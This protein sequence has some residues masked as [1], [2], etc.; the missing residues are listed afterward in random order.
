M[1]K[2]KFVQGTVAE[3]KHWTDRLYSLKIDAAIKPFQPG[4]FGRLGLDI[5]G[6]SIVRPYS[7]VNA[8]GEPFLEFYSITVPDGVLSNHLRHLEPGAPL[9]IA[10][11]AAGFFTLDEVP[12][13]RDLWM[14]ST[15]TALG[16]FLSILKTDL[17]W[18]RFEKIVLVHAVRHA[19][20][21]TYQDTIQKFA[22]RDPE[23]FIMIPFV[24]REPSEV[25]MPGRIPPAIQSGALEKRAGLSIHS[26]YSQVMIC[27]NPDM[28]K[29]TTD[30]LKERGLKKNRR[31]ERG[32][33]TTEN[34]W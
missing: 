33:I 23:K 22:K 19:E 11:A 13:G 9:W 32:H 7:F 34:Y 28:V 27:G 26:D 24:S 12:E 29:D 2:K 30:V 21:L 10:A 16:P 31:R 14:F 20:E 17:P 3:N 18:Q 5:D 25:A 4:Q 1:D 15:G 6:E 8:P